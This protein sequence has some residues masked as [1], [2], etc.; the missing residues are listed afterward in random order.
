MINTPEVSKISA[1]DLNNYDYDDIVEFYDSFEDDDPRTDYHPLFEIELNFFECIE[2]PDV[3]GK[4]SLFD[5]LEIVRYHFVLEPQPIYLDNIK[6]PNYPSI[7]DIYN[8][9]KYHEKDRYDQL[10]ATYPAICVNAIF[11]G[12]KDLKYLIKPTNLMF[13]DLDEFKSTEEALA[14]KNEY[15]AKYDWIISSSLSISKLGLHFIILV[16]DIHDNNDFNRKYDYVSKTYFDSKLDKNGKSLTRFVIIPFDFD[17]YVNYH[18][19]TLYLNDE[20]NLNLTNKSEKGALSDNKRRRREEVMTTECTFLDPNLS[21]PNKKN[22]LVP[23]EFR[24]NIPED[25]FEDLDK[26]LYFFDGIPTMEINLF[27]LKNGS[28]INDGNRTAFIGAVVVKMIFI[29]GESKNDKSDELRK[30]IKRYVSYCNNKYCHPPLSAKE[31]NNSFNYN[32]QRY[33]NGKLNY[34]NLFKT[35]RAFWSKRSR[36][37]GNEKRKITCGIRAE[38][39]QKESHEKIESA[40]SELIGDNKKPTQKKVSELSGLS[41]RT[42]KKYWKDFEGLVKINGKLKT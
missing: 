36:L 42:V 18:P 16:D 3:I 13:L 27:P 24:E 29:N 12:R 33:L 5:Y 40:I 15:T 11:N 17:I 37:K 6:P 25:E 2:N 20:I 28:K 14:K 32:W 39:Q 4:I 41:L 23:L 21:P 22:R 9:H 7:I 1:I 30:S 38:Y 34:D 35:K 31:L 8:V 19:T 10:K 26:P